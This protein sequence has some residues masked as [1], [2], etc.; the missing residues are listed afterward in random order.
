MISILHRYREKKA[1]VRSF[2]VIPFLIWVYAEYRTMIAHTVFW[3]SIKK[4]T[5]V[6]NRL[7]DFDAGCWSRQAQGQQNRSSFAPV[8]TTTRR[9]SIA[10]G[11]GSAMCLEPL[12]LH[13]TRTILPQRTDCTISRQCFRGLAYR[14]YCTPFFLDADRRGN[15]GIGFGHCTEMLICCISNFVGYT[16]ETRH[17]SSVGRAAVL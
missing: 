3:S 15:H 10:R 7:Q 1:G 6:A 17:R 8:F 2:G 13:L 5:C 12:T 14:V 9:L 11:Y 16:C 4:C